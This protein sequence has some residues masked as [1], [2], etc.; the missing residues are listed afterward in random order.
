MSQVLHFSQN[1]PMQHYRLGEEKWK[2]CL[3]KRT[4]GAGQQQLNMSQQCAQV[5]KKASSILACVRN[6]VASWT[7]EGIV[8]LYFALVR[9]HLKSCVWLWAPHDKKDIVVLKHVQGR[10]T[11]LVKAV[12]HKSYKE[13]LRDLGL[14][15]LEKSGSE[16]RPYH[17]LQLP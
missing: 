4:W 13:Q 17:C 8:L 7:R 11:E 5:A 9:P 15:S 10:A 6:S 12:E 1:N 14:L 3:Q 2:R 16:G